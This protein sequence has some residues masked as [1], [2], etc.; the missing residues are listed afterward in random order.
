MID[1]R[2]SL[3]L[4][5]AATLGIYAVWSGDNA[6]TTYLGS[7][8]DAAPAVATQAVAPAGGTVAV[9]DLNPLA[10]LKAEQFA[11]I[12]ARPL[13][14]PTRAP[15]PEAAPQ[16][17]PEDVATVEEAPP[18]EPPS[19]PE[20]FTLLGI[21]AKDG[22]WSVVMRWN[23]TN[24]VFRLSTGGDIQGWTVAEITPQQVTVNRGDQT[25]DIRM[26][27]QKGPG[28]G[29][30]AQ[31]GF[32]ADAIG[33]EEQPYNGGEQQQPP[34]NDPQQISAE[35][36]QQLDGSDQQQVDVNAAQVSNGDGA[37]DEQ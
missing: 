18:A 22:V 37:E 32:D 21:A 4:A 26:F 12:A 8:E 7:T 1:R 3:L 13:F 17:V 15:A 16:E 29:G 23:P 2:M 24:E 11:D 25:L 6:L 35:D 31:G 34:G 20:D 33:N 28:P 36:Q 9:A 5:A 19:N 27:H 14:N 10:G 30:Q